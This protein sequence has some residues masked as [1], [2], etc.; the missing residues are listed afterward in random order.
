[1]RV[2]LWIDAASKERTF[3]GKFY[4]IPILRDPS[5]LCIFEFCFFHTIN[6]LESKSHFF[7]IVIDLILIVNYILS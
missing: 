1:M 3:V 4:N 6:D 7:Q 5:Y 2:H